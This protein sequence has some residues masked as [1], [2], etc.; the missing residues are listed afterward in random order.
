MKTLGLC[1]K[2][3]SAVF[4]YGT[5]ARDKVG[6]QA[7]FDVL[8][9]EMVKARPAQGH[10]I[11]SSLDQ[12]GHLIR[13]Y[14]LNIDGLASAA[15]QTPLVINEEDTKERGG[16]IELHGNIHFVVCCV[17]GTRRPITTLEGLTFRQKRSVRCTQPTCEGEM[18]FAVVLYG[19]KDSGLITPD[20]VL[21]YMVQ[22]AASAAV[23]VWVG[24]SFQ[25]SAS[26]EYFRRVHRGSGLRRH[27][28]VV[29]N[30]E[31]DTLYNL[32]TGCHGLDLSE[33]DLVFAQLGAGQGLGVIQRWVR[34]A[35]AT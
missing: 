17:C 31:E 7:F 19:D 20:S 32:R 14:T 23:V 15:G 26:V 5:F 11:I 27:V 1:S 22:D 28:H 24:I 8:R 34:D 12:S 21:D 2:D 3:P 4:S 35:K 33:H 29:I 10:R 18:R 30:P 6:V 9:R 16:V 25:Q 13:H